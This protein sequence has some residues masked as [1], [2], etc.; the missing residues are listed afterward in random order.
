MTPSHYHDYS[1]AFVDESGY[2]PSIFNRRSPSPRKQ[3]KEDPLSGEFKHTMRVL[4][5]SQSRHFDVPRKIHTVAKQLRE[6]VG[7]L[8]R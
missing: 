6:Y 3:T 8:V 4:D 2:E 1:Q 5:A 7:N